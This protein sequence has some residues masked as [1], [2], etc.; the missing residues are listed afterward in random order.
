[1]RRI[2]PDRGYR[3]LDRCSI[4]EFWHRVRPTSA[5]AQDS[6]HQRLERIGG[7]FLVFI[8]VQ[9]IGETN[10]SERS[11]RSESTRLLA[12]RSLCGIRARPNRT[13]RALQILGGR[14]S[15][16][17]CLAPA[18]SAARGRQLTSASVLLALLYAG[19]GRKIERPFALFDAI[20]MLARK[21]SRHPTICSRSATQEVNERFVRLFAGQVR[22]CD[23]AWR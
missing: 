5:F 10:P 8:V 18:M 14:E 20:L 7:F 1:M 21:R 16:R 17:A 4:R 19:E 2:R 22:S 15:L 6:F 11:L 13:G 3:V 12:C 23:R 9:Q